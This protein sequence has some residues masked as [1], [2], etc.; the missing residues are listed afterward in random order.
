MKQA[1]MAAM[2]AIVTL[3]GCSSAAERAA[4]EAA[5]EEWKTNGPG[6][7]A[8]DAL[9]AEKQ[10]INAAWFSEGTLWIGVWDDGSRRDGYAQAMCEAISIGG[11]HG[12]AYIHVG[13]NRALQAGDLKEI[14][15]YHCKR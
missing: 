14:G 8:L 11:W 6:G 15:K 10:V 1:H 4:A 2:V 5:F 12:D 13:D 7:L 9:R 3:A